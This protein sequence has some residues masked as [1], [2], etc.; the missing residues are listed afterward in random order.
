MRRRHHA[1]QRA[2][3]RTLWAPQLFL[4]PGDTTNVWI[5]FTASERPTHGWQTSDAI[6]G[7]TAFTA[8]VSRARFKQGLPFAD[9]TQN[10]AHEPMPYFYKVNNVQNAPVLKDGGY[11]Q[12]VA[13]GAWRTIP[14]S[15]D[16]N[17]F[18]PSCGHLEE[19]WRTYGHRCQGAWTAI[20]LDTHVYFDPTQSNRR[21]LLY[22]WSHLANPANPNFQGN[23]LAAHPM[24]N[25]NV[26]LD[27]L[28]P[29]SEHI[30]LAHREHGSHVP[31]GH[32]TNGRG[33][34]NASAHWNTAWVEA[35]AAFHW[36]GWTYLIYSRNAWTSPAY[37]IYYRKTSGSFASLAVPGQDQSTPES[38]LV[39]SSTPGQA[40]GHSYG[41]GEI[42]LG[43]GGRPYL[44][45]HYKEPMVFVPG[46]PGMYVHP[47]GWSGRTVYF[48]ELTF[49]ASGN[50]LQLTDAPGVC[51]QAAAH[52]FLVPW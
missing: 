52:R 27:A 26:W 51:G 11:A 20:S 47:S 28:A 25:N 23:N 9:P 36:N 3:V 30:H 8:T 10:R 12:R 34:D 17:L 2:T 46:N 38:I 32:A 19:H 4:A 41:H 44:I 18:G 22:T 5:S 40:Y 42:F 39:R 35:P 33:L 24:L 29:A 13:N 37:G 7:L 31:P 14:V 6:E 21:W 1:Q 45:Y 50:I 48:K 16:L 15:V 43:P 49:D